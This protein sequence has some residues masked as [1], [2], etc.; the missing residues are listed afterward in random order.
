M[1]QNDAKQKVAVVGGG[2]MGNGIAQLSAMNGHEV[3]LADLSEARLDD[4]LATIKTSLERFKKSGRM[5]LEER[6]RVLRRIRT[7]TRIPDAVK[8]ADIVIEAVVERLDVK[9]QVMSEVTHHAPADAVLSTNTSQLSITS[10]G[11]VLGDEAHRVIGMHFFNPAVVMRLV[12]LVCGLETSP[13]TLERAERFAHSLGR[14]TVVCRRDSPGFLT[15]RFSAILRLEALHMLEEGLATAED[16]DKAVK[17]AFNHPMGPLELGDFNGL[18]TF[19]DA[20]KGLYAAHGE[21]FR[22]PVELK[23]MVAAGRL[24]RKSGRGFYDHQPSVKAA[25]GA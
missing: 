10:I 23:N 22:P 4:A 13:E 2:V 19:L 6:D 12:E 1:L 8:G 18:D 17:L 20:L 14:E 5:D 15:S 3:Y 11:S 7:G 9:H 25:P 16:I 21:R 24:G